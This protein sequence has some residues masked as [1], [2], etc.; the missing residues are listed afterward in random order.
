MEGLGDKIY[1]ARKVKG[2]SQ[3]DLAD[4]V[5]VSRQTVSQWEND[6]FQPGS[7]NIDALC[8]V[9]GLKREE[10]AGWTDACDGVDEHPT[11]RKSRTR[12]KALT[13]S[14]AL[15][16][17]AAAIMAVIT[18]LL[19]FITLTSN[20][21]DMVDN[22]YSIPQSTFYVVL[23]LTLIIMVACAVLIVLRVRAKQV[24]S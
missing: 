7:E 6:K 18:V 5:G 1:R 12:E 17:A 22:S 21:G 9:L 13:V 2:L 3:E 23:T 4:S 11:D 15:A 16:S 24:K 19:G 8:R 14:A 10:F 20:T